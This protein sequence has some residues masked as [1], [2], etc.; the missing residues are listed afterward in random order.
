MYGRLKISHHSHSGRLRP[1]EHTSYL[2]LAALVIGVGLVLGVCSFTAG[3]VNASPGPQAGSVGLTGTVPKKAPT[4][5]ATVSQPAN[6]QHFTTSPIDISGTCDAQTMVEVFK[7]DIFAGSSPCGDNG[8]YSFKVDLLI[9]KN[10]LKVQLYDVLNQAGPDSA[11]VTVYYDASLPPTASLSPLDLGGP[12]LLLNTDAVFRGVFPDQPLNVPVSVVG[13]T[14]PYAINV[15]W[16]DSG[17]DVI[18]RDSNQ[19]FNAT[20]TYHKPGTYQITIQASDAKGRVAFLMVAAI[21]NGRPNI[22]PISNVS[23][24]PT[25]KLLVLW[26][27]YAVIV[28]LVV[29]FWMGEQREKRLLKAHA[30]AV[31]PIYHTPAG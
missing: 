14:P 13:G 23:K 29:S 20:H 6:G 8:K 28:T 11:P 1:H 31:G 17:N 27:M 4:V 9:G 30:T 3:K 5:A 15:Q 16:G 2:P 25:N 7:N 22:T 24:T 21:V 19:T 10:V 12:Q 26:P 18:A